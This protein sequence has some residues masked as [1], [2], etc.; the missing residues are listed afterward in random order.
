[1]FAQHPG[2]PNTMDLHAS[3]TRLSAQGKLLSRIAQ[4][5]SMG[6]GVDSINISDRSSFG[7]FEMG[8]IGLIWDKEAINERV[9]G[10]SM[11]F[12]ST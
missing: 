6:F 1:M 9:A 3:Q 10:T 5:T 4:G 8:N 12:R 7:S 2:V 11:V